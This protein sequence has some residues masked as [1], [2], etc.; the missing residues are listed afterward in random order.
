MPN[1]IPSF[2][3]FTP[4]H[5]IVCLFKKPLKTMISKKIKKRDEKEKS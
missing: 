3:F 4:K 5:I 2:I 1:D